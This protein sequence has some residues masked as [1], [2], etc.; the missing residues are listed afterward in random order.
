L[1]ALPSALA[2]TAPRQLAAT[3]MVNTTLILC[4]FIL[5]LAAVAALR[6]PGQTRPALYPVA[7]CR[8]YFL[9]PLGTYN[10]PALAKRSR[11]ALRPL[12]ALCISYACST[13]GSPS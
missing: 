13:N 1:P 9:E 11:A 8:Q 2:R 4:V 6:S 5:I 3:R 12:Q 10:Q 7:A